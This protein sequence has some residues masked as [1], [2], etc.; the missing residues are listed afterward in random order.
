MA[1]FSVENII[2]T[3]IFQPEDAPAYIL[4][5]IAIMILLIV[6]I[7]ASFLL[8]WKKIRL[9]IKKQ[10][11]LAAEM[12]RNGWANEDVP[13]EPERHMFADLTDEQ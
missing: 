10:V 3:E 8:W 4:G 1:S 2:G 5:K 7:T 6:E 13:K 9:N 11:F 12:A